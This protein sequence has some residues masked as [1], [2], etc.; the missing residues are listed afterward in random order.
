MRITLTFLVLFLSTLTITAKLPLDSYVISTSSNPT[1][2]GIS[3]GGGT[4]THGSQVTLVAVSATGYK[5]VDWTLNGTQ[6]STDSTYIFNAESA[7]VY[8]ANFTKKIYS[9]SATPS[10]LLGGT[11]IGSGSY[12]HGKMVNIVA[13]PN[14]G[15]KFNNW[16]E[17]TQVYSSDSSYSFVL[18]KSRIFKGNFSKKIYNLTTKSLPIDAGTTTGDGNYEHGTNVTIVANPGPGWLFA[19]W[20]EDDEILSNNSSYT[21]NITNNRSVIANFAHELYSIS[22][23]P[24]P[25]DAGFVSGSGSSFLGQVV[26]LTATPNIGWAFQHWKEGETI[27]GTSPTYEFTVKGSQVLIAVFSRIT[28]QPQDQT[29]YK[30]QTV[31][32]S[33]E[34]TSEGTTG[35]QWWGGSFKWND[36]DKDRR[37][38][39]VNTVSSSTLTI[40]NV[41]IAEDNQNT[42]TCEVKNLDNYPETGSW[43]NSKTV[44][45]TVLDGE[46]VT[47]VITE[48]PQD[49]NIWVG[50]SATFTCNF[51]G[52]TNK[53]YQWYRV[54]YVSAAESKI[55]DIPGRIEGAT[56]N[57]LNILNISL[58]D[59][60]TQYFCETKDLDFYPQNGSWTNSEIVNLGVEE[61]AL[62]FTRIRS[63]D[64]YITM[65][66]GDYD[67][68]DILDIIMNAEYPSPSTKIFKT[69]DD[70][71]FEKQTILNLPIVEGESQ[72]W[73]D[74]IS[75]AWGDSDND[76]DLDLHLMG[77]NKYSK[78]F[79]NQGQNKFEESSTILKQGSHSKWVDFNNDG[80]LDL[81][82][83]GNS[84]NLYLNK[85]NN[86]FQLSS[87]GNIIKPLNLE[88][89]IEWGDCDN[90]G[91]K[92]LLIGGNIG[93]ISNI[94]NYFSL[95]I[96]QGG[97]SLLE[98]K[99]P[100]DYS[101][102]S[103]IDK[104]IC[105]DSDSDGDLDILLAYRFG[106]KLNRY[107]VV[108]LSN[109]GEN[110]YVE[111]FS[112][113]ELYTATN[114]EFVPNNEI[115]WIDYDNDGDL[116]IF[117]H[118]FKPT[119]YRNNGT[120]QYLLDPFH[121][122]II[123]GTP[124]GNPRWINFAK[125]CDYDNDGDMD[126]F[127]RDWPINL[128][129]NEGTVK[130]TPPTPP[131]SLLATTG[132]KQVTL[133]WDNGTDNETPE[134]GLTYNIAIGTSSK[135]YD[136][137]SP[138][139]NPEN[140][141][142]LIVKRGNT[143]QTREWQIKDLEPGKYYWTVQS[144]DNNYTG[145][146]FAE[147]R[148]F[149]I[150][151]T[152][153]ITIQPGNLSA[154][155]G[156]S[157][158]F[159]V[160]SNCEE[161]LGFQWW[162]ENGKWIDGDKNGRLKI[163]N[164][165][166]S[167]SLIII[168][169]DNSEDNGN[170]F[171]CEVKNLTSY[172]TGGSWINSRTATL[173]V[174]DTFIAVTYPTGGETFTEGETI[175]ITWESQNVDSV[176][177][178]IIDAMFTNPPSLVLNEKYPSIG[179]YYWEA[180]RWFDF[181]YSANIRITDLET[182]KTFTSNRFHIDY[183]NEWQK[184]F[185]TSRS[186]S[187]IYFVN[188]K[189]G[190]LLGVG[191]YKT[192]NG[193]KDW[194]Y[195]GNAQ[196]E[197]M[198]FLNDK[199]GWIAGTNNYLMKTEDGGKS[200]KFRS[201]S[202]GNKILFNDPLNGFLLSQSKVM[203]T[204]DGG[205]TWMEIPL[206]NFVRNDYY[207]IWK[208]IYFKD[209][210]TGYIVGYE[211]GQVEQEGII[212]KSTDG[213]ISWDR[214]HIN[215]TS[216]GGE[217]NRLH[218]LS[219]IEF[220]NEKLGFIVGKRRFADYYNS[221]LYKTNDAGETW[222]TVSID[223]SIDGDW[224]QFSQI[225]F[226]N[227]NEGW[228]SGY[229]INTNGNNSYLLKTIDGGKTWNVDKVING[230]DGTIIRSIFWNSPYLGW[231]LS[232]EKSEEKIEGQDYDISNYCLYEY[233]FTTQKPNYWGLELSVSH[234]Q[235]YLSLSLGQ[236]ELATFDIDLDL[237]ELELPPPPPAGTFDA[238]FIL[239][240]NSATLK[241]FRNSSETDI[242]W[243]IKFQPSESGY[244]ITFTWDKK[245]LPFGSFFLKDAITGSIVNIDMKLHDNY[246]LTNE[247]IDKLQ[248]ISKAEN[249]SNI[250][251]NTD[252]DL[253][254]IPLKSDDMNTSAVFPNATSSA[255]MFDGSYKSRETLK[256]G[257]GYWV[258]FDK[259]D[260]T[261]IY[262]QEIAAPIPVKAGWN[263]IG[264]YDEEIHLANITTSPAGIISS[265]I[266]GFE[267]GYFIADKLE[268]GNGYWVKATQDGEL[269][270]ITSTS[271]GKKVNKLELS[272]DPQISFNIVANDGV[273]DSISLTFG[274]DSIATNGYDPQLGEEEL[275]PLPPLGVFDVR[276]ELPD[277]L[278][279]TY[280]DFRPF[281]VDCYEHIINY[282]LG[283]SSLGLTLSWNLPEGVTL[284]LSDNFGGTVFN[285]SFTSGEGSFTITNTAVNNAKLTLC[286]SD[287]IVSNNDT[288]SIPTVFSLSQNY[289]N[290]FNP[291][292]KI[293]FG[294]PK[295]SKT[296]L[297]IYNL[298]GQEVTRLVNKQLKAGY[299][300]VEFNN[301]NYSSGIYFYRIQAGDYVETKKMIL[302][303]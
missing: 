135:N 113:E 137:L 208:D 194:I 297:V 43:I 155:E 58:E 114:I 157:V 18:L 261:N 206:N 15:W 277:T 33:I 275:P 28:K 96:N 291:S 278:I 152:P 86:V 175:A 5:F 253:I 294:L 173:S 97:N 31:T 112:F 102:V 23:A 293:K 34:A 236:S 197:D 149:E 195:D 299:H 25:I 21:F 4:F 136:I 214:K 169:I 117:C 285:E 72:R 233:N 79:I 91:D 32:F 259:S 64:Y 24:F 42:F 154:N 103:H 172:P 260:T 85:G 38:T 221:S 71:T 213:G 126:L 13:T 162:A 17:G 273:S 212:L 300:E 63:F 257:F 67:N 22:G 167:S 121:Y 89:S 164:T 65:N 39:V 286:Y 301:S 61:R 282:Q 50:E 147:E 229:R 51:T 179:Y 292:T 281:E 272:S 92:D 14:I 59:N 156:D 207:P 139:A 107:K 74:G 60:G 143:D 231:F 70:G 134:S 239:S 77:K 3:S 267:N 46:P 191:G 230:E 250:T 2:G 19:N 145:S 209:K 265:G 98:I 83:I 205:F 226:V 123:E 45:L 237:D 274:L 163:V 27:V 10:P 171:T 201:T 16:T 9:V 268:V 153:R 93:T 84:S 26:K 255:F 116:D 204:V 222:H 202:R 243:D 232:L 228:I 132:D 49:Q 53:G 29:I 296:S 100:F 47:P 189:L 287:V 111:K 118:N 12:D 90:D 165:S 248:I 80:K 20:T 290:P 200:W 40:T 106:E 130:N 180:S 48:Q 258:K 55:V 276:I 246:T 184:I 75:L 88:G 264:I 159:R 185:E 127:T 219:D 240:N 176:K 225:N 119:F 251:N 235:E 269:S 256:N 62:S 109:E 105:G 254:S 181:P 217:E 8:L 138:M 262:G 241:D 161:P 238:R 280:S 252:W 133:D 99:L 183:K 215:W 158:I 245:N 227:Q 120:G 190:Y 199:E 6:V 284:N 11:I 295:E 188:D 168:N 288:E 35:F 193:G 198:F 223:V 266:Y 73:N 210:S 151:Y 178:E 218:E 95:L 220:V 174:R 44:T 279:T 177:I 182:N 101:A 69:L 57:Q 211:G 186:I 271:L 108:L 247:S 244:P 87:I 56:T 170:T 104:A 166:N 270:F 30:G 1:H 249:Q 192:L 302:L 283:D 66:I 298:L 94:N 142:R 82:I 129:R 289:P 144:I 234:N 54:P 122:N 78:I 37:L 160:E 224:D 128:Y 115:L 125:T 68:D 216:E 110:Q 41:N 131:D 196:G 146:N 140:G 203:K 76:G 187:K 148:F 150:P 141:K 36:G 124:A 7:G 303:K 263:M 242:I 52:P 81:F